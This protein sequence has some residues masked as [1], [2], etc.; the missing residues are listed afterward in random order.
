MASLRLLPSADFASAAFARQTMH[1]QLFGP[2]R[3]ANNC[4]KSPQLWR[5]T[6]RKASLGDGM[7]SI[8]PPELRQLV[9]PLAEPVQAEREADAFFRG[10]EDDE[11][12]GLGGAE[13]TQELFVHHDFGDAAIGQAADK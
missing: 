4:S 5:S 12:R 3:A 8:A 6:S 9:V 10:L 11:G 13:L 2:P 7:G 1:Q